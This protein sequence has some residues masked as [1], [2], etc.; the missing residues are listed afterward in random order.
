MKTWLVI[1]AV[2]TPL[3][4]MACTLESPEKA[5]ARGVFFEQ[6]CVKHAPVSDSTQAGIC[7]TMARRLADK[8]ITLSVELEREFQSQ[9]DKANREIK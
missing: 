4:L 2:V 3:L 6:W 8:E 9:W 1:G 5:Y 7:A